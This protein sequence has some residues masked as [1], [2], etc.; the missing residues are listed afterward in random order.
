[1][2][3]SDTWSLDDMSSRTDAK[4]HGISNTLDY[5]DHSERR[6]IENLRV[7]A[8]YLEYVQRS[9]GYR[10]KIIRSYLCAPLATAMGLHPTTH[11]ILGFGVV[12]TCAPYGD[13]ETV[14]IRLEST[15]YDIIALCAD[16]V[17]MSFAP[18][19]RK[20]SRLQP[21]EQANG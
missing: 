13:P 17:F 10:I 18:Q 9:L 15:D 4:L 12:F 5:F 1:M 6:I 19:Q 7:T 16:G 14:A 20:I 8:T 2:Q 11:H 21:R 3:L